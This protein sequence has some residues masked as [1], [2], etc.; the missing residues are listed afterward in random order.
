MSRGVK[1]DEEILWQ[2][3]GRNRPLFVLSAA[4]GLV[5]L[6]LLVLAEA[7]PV[8]A[9]LFAGLVTLLGVTFAEVSVVVD[10]KRVSAGFGP[11]GWPHRS[12]PLK[13]LVR[14][15]TTRIESERRGGTA[16]KV[17][18]FWPQRTGM[19]VRPGEGLV[20]ESH[21][22]PFI[23][24]VDGAPDAAAVINHLLGSGK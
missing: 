3:Q 5:L 9:A 1:G 6:F 19:V 10:R 23:V 15:G 21:G 11:W 2:G 20:L 8:I 14:V 17:G 4:I 7:H 18:L 16:S 13:G 24:S 12:F 22:P